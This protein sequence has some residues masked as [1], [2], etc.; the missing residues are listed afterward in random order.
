[1]AGEFCSLHVVHKIVKRRD[2]GSSDSSK[3]HTPND[4]TSY[5]E[6]SPPGDPTTSHWCQKPVSQVISI[7]ASAECRRSN[8][9]P[10]ATDS[11][12]GFLQK[13]IVHLVTVRI[14]DSP[15]S[16]DSPCLPFLPQYSLI[17]VP[18]YGQP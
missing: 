14:F 3:G 11:H 9:E 12:L 16:H 5:S 17:S 15:K 18:S 13:A 10:R 6:A 1:M 2:W 4:L 8:P 7:W